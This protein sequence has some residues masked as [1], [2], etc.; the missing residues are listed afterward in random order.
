MI[1]TVVPGEHLPDAAAEPQLNV[2]AGRVHLIVTPTEL[3]ILVDALRS[4]GN[5]ELA[6]RFE[7]VLHRFSK[8]PR[9][10]DDG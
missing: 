2:D 10:A 4:V 3:G 8:N 7:A 9:P 5:R 1:P 6:E